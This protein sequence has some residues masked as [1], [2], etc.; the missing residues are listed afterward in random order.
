MDSRRAETLEALSAY[1]QNQKSLLARTQ[2]DIERLKQLKGEVLASP[3]QLV[4]GHNN[5]GNVISISQLLST[6]EKISELQDCH[7]T[8]SFPDKIDWEA[9]STSDATP[10]RTLA[11]R[12]RLD[13]TQRSVPS[14][15]QR[16]PLSALQKFVKDARKIILDPVLESISGPA[17]TS[18][19][20][21]ITPTSNNVNTSASSGDPD[22][23]TPILPPSL[24]EDEDEEE[25]LTPV[26][27]E[28]MTATRKRERARAKIR[29]LKKRKIRSDL[30][31]GCKLGEE[32]SHAVFVRHDVEDESG[33]VDVS[34]EIARSSMSATPMDGPSEQAS[35]A[36]DADSSIAETL[37]E[38]SQNTKQLAPARARPTTTRQ[39]IPLPATSLSRSSRTRKPSLKLQSQSLGVK[40]EL[41]S[42]SSPTPLTPTPSQSLGKR[43]R[44]T[45]EV[46]NT[47]RK[48]K[49][50]P[51]PAQTDA[52]AETDK[53]RSDTYKQAWSVS[54]QHLLERLLE[55]IPDG[56]RNRWAKI[57]QAMG[58]KRTPRQVASRVQKYFEKLKRFGVGVDKKGKAVLSK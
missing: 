51:P 54:E 10:L 20:L 17:H 58:G 44:D 23:S 55:E 15:T 16:S 3:K 5:Q 25:P 37:V 33:E 8:L 12:T 29:E 35:D 24:S 2:A 38:T 45:P 30:V 21:N 41:K 49:T 22:V 32:G 53:N 28:S 13:H 11:I 31:V 40:A 14:T 6:G 52:S 39:R 9:F 56:E 48:L 1:I 46:S 19:P 50:E 34:M 27:Q 4:N 43:S 42:E 18:A 7:P 57:S 47:T 36:M 26:V